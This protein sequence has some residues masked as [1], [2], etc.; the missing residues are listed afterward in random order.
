MNQCKQFLFQVDFNQ[1]SCRRNRPRR[2][3]L[4]QVEILRIRTLFS[5]NNI[6]YF[7]SQIWGCCVYILISFKKKLIFLFCKTVT[8]HSNIKLK[9]LVSF[10]CIVSGFLTIWY[11]FCCYWKRSGRYCTYCHPNCIFIIFKVSTCK[12]WVTK[13]VNES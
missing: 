12:S 13:K 5:V 6:N 1:L 4:F 3:N 11:L 7:Y 10:S 8:K 2:G 9:Y